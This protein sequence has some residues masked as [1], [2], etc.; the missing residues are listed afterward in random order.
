MRNYLRVLN[1][2]TATATALI[3]YNLASAGVLGESSSSLYTH[4]APF[5]PLLSPRAAIITLDEISMINSQFGEYFNENLATFA[6]GLNVLLWMGLV[7]FPFVQ[8]F[9]YI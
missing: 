6:A 9:L 8:V 7:C 1:G 5:I 4:S 3:L 2:K